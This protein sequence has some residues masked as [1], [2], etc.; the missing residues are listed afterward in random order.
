MHNPGTPANNHKPAQTELQNRMRELNEQACLLIDSNPAQARDLCITAISLATQP[1]IDSQSSLHE[2]AKAQNNLASL[3]YR[4]SH[5]ND[6][7]HHALPALSFYR[8]IAD[9]RAETSIQILIGKIYL[10]LGDFSRAMESELAALRLAEQLEDKE[11]QARTLEVIGAIY[12]S[13]GD[14]SNALQYFQQSLELLQAL[15]IEDSEALTLL[16]ASNSYRNLDNLV[17]ALTYS[18]KSLQIYQKLD[19]QKGQIESMLEIGRIYND[20]SDH[21]QALEYFQNS[22]EVAQ[23]FGSNHLEARAF[24]NLGRTQNFLADYNESIPLLEK[25]L[26]IAQRISSRRLIYIIYQELAESNRSLGQYERALECMQHYIRSRDEVI[27]ER[28]EIRLDALQISH[29]LETANKEAEISQLRNVSLKGEIEDR[30]KAE[31]SLQISNQK[32]RQ[33]IKERE[34][35]IS[36]LDAFTHMVAH[37]LKGPL[38]IIIGYSEI[39]A[40]DILESI[41]QQSADSLNNVLHMSYKMN[42]IIDELLILASIRRENISLKAIDMDTIVSEVENRIDHMI[43]NTAATI[44]KPTSWPTAMGNASWIEEVWTNYMTNAIKY[45]GKPPVLQLGAT[46]LDDGFVRFW[47]QDNGS[48]LP[49]ELQKELFQPFTRLEEFKAKGHGL[50]LSIVKRIIDKLGGEVNY[51]SAGEVGSGSI[52]SFTLP[53]IP[54]LSTS[55]PS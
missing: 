1:A 6:A 17:Q 36:D 3:D 24:L 44:H 39:L 35:L 25:A 10:D 13:L 23:S 2:L 27:N 46:P 8:D 12:N 9:K 52:F 55:D 5:F 33:E 32:L 51:E 21:Q 4:V 30:K 29:D 54:E 37:D 40:E 43:Q 20:M 42:R 16:H 53:G 26:T 11:L 14:F 18:E 22:L 38:N 48:G 7:L 31:Q 34:S 47:I 15:Q 50:G 28:I 49:E 41:D 45:G 19:Q